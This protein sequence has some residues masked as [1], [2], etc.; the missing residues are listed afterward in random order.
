MPNSTITESFQLIIQQITIYYGLFILITGVFGCL[1]NILVFTTLKTFQR[2]PCIFYLTIA[3]IVNV[4][5]LLTSLLV[6]ILAI[7]FYINLTAVSWFCKCRVFLL[8][9]CALV[10]LI[11]MSL[12]TV[13]QF[14]S[15][16]HRHLSSLQLAHR[17]IIMACIIS[18]FHGIFFLIYY[19]T[20]HDVC[21]IINVNFAKYFS[22]FYFPV[23][24]GLVPVLTMVIFASLAFFNI[25]TIASR[26]VHIIR[27]SRD[28]QVTAMVL[29][30]V[31]FIVLSTVPYIISNIYSLSLVTTDQL[32]IAQSYLANSITI[33]LYYGSYAVSCLFES[34]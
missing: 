20:P 33:L 6:R 7:G 8:Q 9:F 10:S 4:G 34:R 2:V 15:M 11:C 25:R 22:Y 5:Q 12:A 28:R 29:V 30:Q 24:L 23:L 32:L 13:D 3:S 31:V 1:L 17:H 19:D 18:S 27:L 14:M 16:T 26:H 21:E